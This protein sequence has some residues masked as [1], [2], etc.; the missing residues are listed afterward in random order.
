MQNAGEILPGPAGYPR[1]WYWSPRTY[2]I[3]KLQIWDSVK[4][5]SRTFL[6]KVLPGALARK[7]LYSNTTPSWQ[8]YEGYKAIMAFTDDELA[9][10]YKDK[11]SNWGLQ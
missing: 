4:A 10:T 7:I 9:T 11:N 8:M 5:S 6:S 3:V 2:K 1:E